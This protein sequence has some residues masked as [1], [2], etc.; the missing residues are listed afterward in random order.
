MIK[1]LAYSYIERQR[2]QK[3]EMK[4]QALHGEG[5]PHAVIMFFMTGVAF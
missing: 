4:I 1:L 2:R 3:S 5:G